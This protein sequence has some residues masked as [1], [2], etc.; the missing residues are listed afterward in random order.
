MSVLLDT[1]V[2]LWYV[3]GDSRISRT[4][5]ALIDDTPGTLISVASLWEMSIKYSLGKLLVGTSYTELI[6]ELIDINEM[7][8]LP[9]TPTDTYAV[10]VL[11]YPHG[12]K[13]KDPFDRLLIAQCH[14]NECSIL[15]RDEKFDAYG[16]DRIW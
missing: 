3:Q 5:H 15:S 1:H 2:F 11:D 12:D 7:Q 10:A 8:I 14:T 16:I 4:A 13:H 9:I 6:P